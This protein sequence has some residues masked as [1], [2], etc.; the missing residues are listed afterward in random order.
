MKE[1]Q[2]EIRINI[3][4]ATARAAGEWYEAELARNPALAERLQP[5]TRKFLEGLSKR[6]GKRISLEHDFAQRFV[7]GWRKTFIRS[8]CGDLLLVNQHE[9]RALT[10]IYALAELVANISAALKRGEGRP[11]KIDPLE[12]YVDAV[13]QRKRT[14]YIG[15]TS[16]FI[17][18]V[19]G[20]DKKTVEKALAKGRRLFE[21]MEKARKLPK[22]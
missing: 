7:L 5:D 20:I 4:P 18:D 21:F 13:E 22:Q 9:D 2:H 16:D 15:R 8:R 11:P 14:G 1:V 3:R 10:G 6:T 17:A 12:A 19:E